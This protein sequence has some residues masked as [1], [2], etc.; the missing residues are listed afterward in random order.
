MSSTPGFTKNVQ[1]IQI[2]S[3]VTLLD[4]PGVIFSEEGE[5]SLVLRNIIKIENV[6][7]PISPIEE[8]MK[9]VNKTDLLLLYKIPDFKNANEFII[10]VAMS[11]G[12]L[13]QVNIK[14]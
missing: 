13:K 2:D 4:S 14:I 9:K 1:E 3:K 10:N 7:D 12:K 5:K 8:I 6:V 11:R